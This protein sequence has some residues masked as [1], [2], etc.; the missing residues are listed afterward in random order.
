MQDLT[1]NVD[2][3]DENKLEQGLNGGK[4]MS[5]SLTPSCSSDFK[6]KVN[7]PDLQLQALLS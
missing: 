5:V 2:A 1:L 3:E 7:S 4:K 6:D